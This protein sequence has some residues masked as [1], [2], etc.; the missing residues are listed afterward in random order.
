METISFNRRRSNTIEDLD[1]GQATIVRGLIETHSK[2][3]GS[4]N[5]SDTIKDGFAAHD[6]RDIKPDKIS[7]DINFFVSVPNYFG[8]SLSSRIF[9]KEHYR[10]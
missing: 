1:D 4:Y 6:L 8:S 3:K 7:K 2:Y 5:Y 10:N 9:K